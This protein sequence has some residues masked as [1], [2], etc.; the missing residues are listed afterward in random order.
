MCDPEGNLCDK[1]K[2][3]ESNEEA[4]YL[5]LAEESEENKFSVNNQRVKTKG[6]R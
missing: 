2:M 4:Y 3:A 5:N 6:E 1:C